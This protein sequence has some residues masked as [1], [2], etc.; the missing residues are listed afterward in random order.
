MFQGFPPFSVVSPPPLCGITPT[1]FS[2][3]SISSSNVIVSILF[4]ILHI[5]STLFQDPSSSKTHQDAFLPGRLRHQD[6]LNI[7]QHCFKTLQD[8]LNIFQHFFKTLQG[9]LCATEV[10]FFGAC[11]CTDP[12]C[13]VQLPCAGEV[14]VKSNPPRECAR[15]A[16]PR[17]VSQHFRAGK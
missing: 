11:R 6:P 2:S 13:V 7:F 10:L 15:F 16:G 14:T 1:S 5:F 4:K 3:Y 8:P 9:P 12:H 17:L